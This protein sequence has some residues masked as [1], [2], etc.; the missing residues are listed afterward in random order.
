[1]VAAA[2]V[3]LT[4]A[5]SSDVTADEP[6][7]AEPTDWVIVSF[8]GTDDEIDLDLFEA[9]FEFEVAADE[10]L[11]SA[12]AGSIDGNEIGNYG[13]DLYFVG[14]DAGTMWE[15]IEPVFESAPMAWS[16]VELREGLDD[17][18]PEVITR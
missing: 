8:E 2:L 7:R 17:A 16:R 3:A 9:M 5:C 14:F 18:A 11:Q 12:G 6:T 1:M 4:T 13:Y 15:L 10:A